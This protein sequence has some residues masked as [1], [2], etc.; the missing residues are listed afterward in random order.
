MVFLVA[1]LV[2]LII[3]WRFASNVKKDLDTPP[4]GSVGATVLVEFSQST[5][6]Q[7]MELSAEPILIKSDEGGVR[8]QIEHRPMLPLMAFVGQDVSA[9][10]TEAAARVTEKFGASWVAL[11]SAREDG[12]ASVQRLA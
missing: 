12:H 3:L 5:T 6:R 8:V 9:A 11:V 2:V 4:A 1:M 10:L 7:L